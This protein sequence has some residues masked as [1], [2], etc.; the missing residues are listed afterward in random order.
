[1][2]VCLQAQSVLA[3]LLPN[4]R[5]LLWDPVVRVRVAMAQLLE[6]VSTLNTIKWTSIVSAAE[7]VDIL[8]TDKSAVGPII[9]R[10]LFSQFVNK[11]AHMDMEVCSPGI[12]SVLNL[13]RCASSRI[14]SRGKLS[15]V[16]QRVHGV[17]SSWRGKATSVSSCLD[18]DTLLSTTCPSSEEHVAVGFPTS[19]KVAISHAKWEVDKV[20]HECRRLRGCFSSCTPMPRLGWRSVASWPHSLRMADARCPC[21]MSSRLLCCSAHTC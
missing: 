3:I 10:L 11:V 18:E 12:L 4:L 13:C 17:P 5:R 14:S 15:V 7:L 9:Q 8:A 21:R 6:R 16:G 19:R 20:L 1:M 2:H